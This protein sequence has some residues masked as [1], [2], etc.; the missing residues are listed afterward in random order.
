V[1]DITAR[2]GLPL[3]VPGQAAKDIVHN[4]AL[5]RLSILVE[6][7][8][9]TIGLTVPPA[10]PVPGQ[11][12]IVGTTPTDAWEGHANAIAGW[13]EGG[14]RITTPTEGMRAWVIDTEMTAR[15]AGG[16]WTV[17]QLRAARLI[18]ADVPS[19]GP[20]QPAIENPAGGNNIDVESRACLLSVLDALREHG[21]IER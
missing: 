9:E 14:W 5:A 20:I 7:A 18:I 6:A 11:A 3:I 19:V 4:E 2:L 1:N 15:F 13:T 12:W 8:V 17:G 21:L 16:G 10:D